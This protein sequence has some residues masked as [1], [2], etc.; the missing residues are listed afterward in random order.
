M[1]VLTSSMVNGTYPIKFVR[2]PSS[3]RAD[4]YTITVTSGAL[5]ITTKSSG[6][7]GGGGGSAGGGSTPAIGDEKEVK[8]SVT[9]TVKNRR[10]QASVDSNMVTEALEKIAKGATIAFNVENTKNVN[11]V[12]VQMKNQSIKALADSKTGLVT[13]ASEVGI[14]DIEDKTLESIA[15]QA[16]TSDISINLGKSR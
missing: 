5:T 4:N 3:L 1:S 12:T 7:S 15:K 11:A 16:G 13:I 2:T 6:G 14:M 9:S 10:A 8:T